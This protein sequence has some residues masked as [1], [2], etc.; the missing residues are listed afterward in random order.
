MNRLRSRRRSLED[1]RERIRELEARLAKD[2]HNSSRPPSSDSPFKKPPPRSQRRRS[3]GKRGSV[4]DERSVRRDGRRTNV[5]RRRPWPSP[6][7]LH[8]KS[9]GPHFG[10]RKKW[11]RSG[12]KRAQARWITGPTRYH[13]LPGRSLRPVRD[14][15]VNG[16][17][18]LRMLRHRDRGYSARGAAPGGRGGDL[19]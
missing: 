2:S 3:T 14:H 19:A 10:F 4:S 8:P 16:D 12:T 9:D 15:P 6:D 1:L 13:S 17:L 7:F 5:G 11:R 18:R